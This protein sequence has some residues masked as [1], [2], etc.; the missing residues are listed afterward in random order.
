MEVSSSSSTEPHS[1]RRLVLFALLLLFSNI[2]S[3]LAQEPQIVV[4]TVGNQ[5]ITQKELDDSVLSKILPL[6]Q[7]MYALR[8][9]ALQNLISRKLLEHEAARRNLSVDQLRQQLVSGPVVVAATE[10]E[11]LYQQNLNVFALLSQDEAKE[12][13]RLD[14]EGQARLKRYREAVS[15]L[16]RTYPVEV[17]LKEPRFTLM[18]ESTTSIRGAMNAKVVITEFADFQCGYCKQVQPALKQLLQIYPNDVQLN[19]RALTSTSQP[20]SVVSAEA[21]MCAGKQGNFWEFHDGLFAATS[22]STESLRHL[23]QVLRLNVGE[24]QKCL[25]SGEMR[26]VIEADLREAQRLGINAT[27]TF[28]INGTLLIGAASLQ[29]FKA[30]V[31]QELNRVPSGSEH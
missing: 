21:A 10:V 3:L 18:T 2:P 19:F 13:L 26:K 7:Q 17:L 14:L 9:V 20:L 22:L 12:K 23:A 27:P 6:Q 24:F 11:E 15:A 25:S 1:F 30:V 4:A 5:P 16:K 28:L 29:E 31:E 8:K